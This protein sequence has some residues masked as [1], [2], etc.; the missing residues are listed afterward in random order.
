VAGT[1]SYELTKNGKVIQEKTSLEID[2]T[3]QVDVDVRP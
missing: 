1:K 2:F 3:L